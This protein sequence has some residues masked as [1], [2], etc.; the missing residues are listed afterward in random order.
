M[1][2]PSIFISQTDRLVSEFSRLGD[3]ASPSTRYI[4]LHP[5][6]VACYDSILRHEKSWNNGGADF[7]TI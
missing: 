7:F 3:Y 5:A 2:I 1:Y 6:M 4:R